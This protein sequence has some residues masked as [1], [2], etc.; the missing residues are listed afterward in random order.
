[1]QPYGFQFQR[2]ESMSVQC[3]N[4]LFSQPIYGPPTSTYVNPTE[5][6]YSPPNYSYLTPAMG[7]QYPEDLLSP[8]AP[9]FRFVPLQIRSDEPPTQSRKNSTLNPEAPT[10]TPTTFVLAHRRKESAPLSP[11]SQ[12]QKS[13]FFPPQPPP[14]EAVEPPVER[15]KNRRYSADAV[16]LIVHRLSL[17]SAG[18]K[19]HKRNQLS[20]TTDSSL[21]S[22]EEGKKARWG[23]LVENEEANGETMN[24]LEGAVIAV[25]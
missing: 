20:N 18:S 15:S 10:F 5:L 3:N 2:G 25:S 21:E 22:V 7:T 17:R 13:P 12:P 4:S 23:S 8:S 14:K 9:N 19:K 24:W 6:L 1:M 16:D 11:F